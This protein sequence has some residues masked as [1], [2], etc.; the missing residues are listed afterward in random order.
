MEDGDLS[1]F[2]NVEAQKANQNRG[3]LC[4]GDVCVMR[5]YFLHENL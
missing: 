2:F 4:A 3:S 1:F 5:K